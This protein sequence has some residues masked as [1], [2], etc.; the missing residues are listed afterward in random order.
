METENTGMAVLTQDA[1]VAGADVKHSGVVGLA[2]LAV[3][4]ETHPGITWPTMVMNIPVPGETREEVMSDPLGLRI[5]IRRF[6]GVTV[7]A[8]VSAWPVLAVA[9][10]SGVAA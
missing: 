1:A 7:S 3:H 9:P 2:D 4:L 6:E 5:M 10:G 8:H